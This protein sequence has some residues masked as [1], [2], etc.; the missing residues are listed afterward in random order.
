MSRRKKKIW[1]IEKIPD[2]S[3]LYRRFPKKQYDEKKG[4]V[5]FGAFMLRRHLNEEALSVDWSNWSTPEKSSVDS[6]TG[7]RY[8]LGAL[9]A[10]VP[11]HQGLKVIHAPSRDNR[12]HSK[13]AGQRLIDESSR[14]LVADILAENCRPLIT[15]IG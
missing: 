9:Y 7:R 8:Y 14:L 6:N 15:S 11:R 10:K 4:K 13:I 12:A 1:K 5:S 3:D 2:E